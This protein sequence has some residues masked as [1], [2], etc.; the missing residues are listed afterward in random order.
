MEPARSLSETGSASRRERL[1]LRLAVHHRPGEARGEFMCL[2]LRAPPAAVLERPS[3]PATVLG[4]STWMTP[5]LGSGNTLTRFRPD[6][7][8]LYVWR[9][10]FVRAIIRFLS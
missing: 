6:S 5:V 8:A 3:E 2:P 1:G 9:S 4:H 10:R 7:P